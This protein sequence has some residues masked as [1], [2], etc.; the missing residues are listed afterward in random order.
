MDFFSVLLHNI[1]NRNTPINDD[2]SAG[3]VISTSGSSNLNSDYNNTLH[4][5]VYLNEKIINPNDL[6]N[7]KINN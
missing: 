3:Q 5:E 4:F 6:F 7:N 2:I 1:A